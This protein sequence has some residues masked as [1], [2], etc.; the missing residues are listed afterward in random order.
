M[1]L[2]T[3]TAPD[4]I[5]QRRRFLEALYDTAVRAV[6][7]RL[8]LPALLPPPPAG[9][10]LIFACG[11]AAGSM[12]EAAERHYREHYGLGPDRLQG[13]GV[14]RHGYEGN[15]RLIEVIGAGHP[16]PDQ[17]GIAATERTL[18]LAANATADDL[19]VVLISGGGSANWIAPAGQLQLAEK[20]A[21]TRALLKSGADI[22]EINTVRKHLSRIKGGRLAALLAPA[23]IASFAISDVP[24]DDP[25][26]IASGPTVP[27]ATTLADARAVLAK[28][29]VPLAGEIGRLLEDPASESPKPGDA[30]FAAS[31]FTIVSRPADAIIA[32]EREIRQAGYTLVSHGAD[33]VGEARE[34]AAGHAREALAL[35]QQGKRAVLLSGGELT[36]T[37]RG[38]GNGGPNQEYALALAIALHGTPGISALAGDTDGTDGGHG[39]PSDPA[40]AIIDETTLARAEAA[41]VSPQLCLKNNDSTAFF[42]QIG[43]LLQPGPTLT[44]ANDLRAIV[45][46]P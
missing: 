24:G 30:A 15:T 45:I 17:A 5:A 28:Y 44:N 13:L 36:V 8:T 43:D 21:L 22:G 37:I 18:A 27:D 20:Q 42:A 10:V 46:E 26:T 16:V 12:T 29:G 2:T 33:I 38:E 3:N 34:V 4:S 41:G 40:G 25:S 1:P 11:K 14:A 6:H 9:R 31:Q 7:P 23:R 32:V 19:A 39:L 35:R